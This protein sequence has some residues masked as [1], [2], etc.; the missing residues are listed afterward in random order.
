[1]PSHRQQRHAE[2][3]RAFAELV[4]R[5][6]HVT[7]TALSEATGHKLETVGDWLRRSEERSEVAKV[8]SKAGF[9]VQGRYTLPGAPNAFSGHEKRPSDTTEA[10][11]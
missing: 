1:M 7:A 2:R 9:S 5:D 4:E 11:T 8:V 3:M 6:G 10:S